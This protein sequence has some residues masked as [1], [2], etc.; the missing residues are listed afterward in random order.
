MK[1]VRS[2]II[3]MTL[4]GFVFTS[5]KKTTT[6][7]TPENNSVVAWAVGAMDTNN[8]GMILYT[9]DAGETWKRQGEATMFQGIE[10]NNVWAIDQQNAW[11]VCSGNRIYRTINGGEN[12]IQV[13]APNIPGNPDLTGISI[14]DNTTLWVSG[15][16][17]TVYSSSDAGNNWTVYDTTNFR[18]GMMQGIHAITRNIIYAA[19]ELTLQ[20]GTWGYLVRTLNGGITWD[21]ISLPGNY[22]QHAWIGVTAT[23]SNNVIVY[24]QTG[25][26]AVTR[27]GGNY[28]YTADPVSPSD[29]NSLVML[30]PESFWGACDFDLIF[31]TFDGGETW[32]EQTSQGP[33]NQ[34]LVGIDTYYTQTALIVGESADS[35]RSGKIL[36]T[37]D[38]GNNW[39]LRHVCAAKL[40]KVS[41][42]KPQGK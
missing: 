14:I 24:G 4:T 32:L 23:D 35:T 25:H 41:F 11:I 37:R 28:W 31:K 13:L 6:P 33:S 22:N 19:G 8:V 27:N 10:I 15:D 16:R 7:E 20:M 38:G 40:N 39:S 1:T 34:Y 9:D 2:L 26:Y 42:A 18:H 3:L 30:S 21:S 36:R 17:G 5:C 12:W 29:I